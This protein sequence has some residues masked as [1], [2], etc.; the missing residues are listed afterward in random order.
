M[1]AAFYQGLAIFPLGTYTA[2][3]HPIYVSLISSISLEKAGLKDEKLLP[4]S[5][6]R[7]ANVAQVTE[8]WPTM[9][10][11]PG[12]GLAREGCRWAAGRTYL[13]GYNG[14][15]SRGSFCHKPET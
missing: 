1:Q 5:A 8:P 7:T 12:A 6:H 2:L 4:T 13:L 15:L 9:A 10:R 11:W 14:E 3:T